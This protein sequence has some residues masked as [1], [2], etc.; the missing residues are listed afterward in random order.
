[1]QATSV[2][3]DANGDAVHPFA[4]DASGQLR[5]VHASDY[6]AQPG[7]TLVTL[8]AAVRPFTPDQPAAAIDVQLGV[9]PRRSRRA[10]G[11]VGGRRLRLRARRPEQSDRGPAGARRRGDD[12]HHADAVRADED[13][14]PARRGNR[15]GTEFSHQYTV[16][17]DIAQGQTVD[18]LVI[19]DT[20]PDG[21][22]IDGA[23]AAGATVQVQQATN[24]V[25]ATFNAPITGA[26][27]PD[28]TMVINFHVGETLAPGDP[29]TP[30]LDPAT[31]A[32]RALENN[33]AATADWTPSIP[34]TIRRPSSSIPP[35]RRT[36][37]SR[38][39]LPC[40][41]RRRF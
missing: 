12:V 19:L 41:K 35:V 20:L 37:S 29:T 10:A 11:S 9:S 27:G 16:T 30:V 39:R 15:D 17:L 36:S 4:R 38:R 32:S 5:V 34:G 22:V 1:M 7:D 23:S 21:V 24:E 33:V 25:T 8:Q 28:A 26:A 18:N 3:F 13:L 6:G 40:R 14:E 31:G 2:E